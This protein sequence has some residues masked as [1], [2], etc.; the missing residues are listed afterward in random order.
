METLVMFYIPY[1]RVFNNLEK[2]RSYFNHK[3]LHSFTYSSGYKNLP[4]TIFKNIEVLFEQEDYKRES[5]V[6]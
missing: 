3:H 6:Q 1:T 2:I 4:N 5:K